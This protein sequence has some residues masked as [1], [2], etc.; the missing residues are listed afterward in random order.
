ML[1]IKSRLSDELESLIHRTIGCL[2][3]VH[4]VLGP[5]LL[6]GIYAR[7][8]SLELQANQIP[9][10]IE[11]PVP[12]WYRGQLLCHQRLDLM[13]AGELIV[14]IE[15]VERLAPVHQAQLLSYMR[16]TGVQV[17]LLVNFNVA[18]LQGG[19]KRVVL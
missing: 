11:K 18:V 17:G 14:E 19:L 4:R 2:I 15:A 8:V 13:V 16:L 5:G 6:E 7:A 10:E 12:V 1:R 9:F 3:T